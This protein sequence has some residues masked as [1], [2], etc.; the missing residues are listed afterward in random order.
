MRKLRGFSRG[1]DGYAVSVALILGALIGVLLAAAAT[2][3]LSENRRGESSIRRSTAFHAAE[4]GV[5]DYTA[6]LTEDHYFFQH[7]VHEGESTRTR[8]GGGTVAADQPWP[9]E[10]TWTY[11]NGR[12]AWKPLGNGYEFNLQIKPPSPGSLTVTLVSTGRRAGSTHEL[13]SIEATVRPAS[14]AD[15]FRVVNGD[16]SWGPTASTFGKLYAGD[17]HNIDHAGTA[18]ADVYAEGR[19]TRQPTYAPGTGAAG[20]DGTTCPNGASCIRNKVKSPIVVSSLTQSSLEDIRSAAQ[21]PG[22]AGGLYLNDTTNPIADAWQMRFTNDGTVWYRECY[23][24]NGQDIGERAPNCTGTQLS[25]TIP[26]N[27]AIY[28]KQSLVI[29]GPSGG[30][31][32]AGVVDG[33]VTAATEG[34]LY[35]GANLAYE[36]SGDDVLGIIAQDEIVIT[37][38]SPSTLNWR[39]AVIAQNGDWHTWSSS[40][41]HNTMNFTGSST[42]DQGGDLTMFDVRN[43]VYDTTLL[44]LPPPWFPI[45]EDTYTISF[46]RELNPGT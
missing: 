3:G 11:A 41:S 30:I 12:N 26:T 19:I 15:F 33:R 38:W 16:I 2:R 8:A 42:T 5:D 37:E 32:N 4:A 17:G 14:L 36:T 31:G 44:F 43:Y 21:V 25:R 46:F 18:H 7:F 39:A 40:G 9:N 6:K 45:L 27:G 10:G 35:V 1:E 22:P 24:A 13:R 20:Y 28:A 34:S 23:E 29:I